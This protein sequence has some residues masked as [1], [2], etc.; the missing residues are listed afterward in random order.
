MDSIVD[1]T[2]FNLFK[3]LSGVDNSSNTICIDS[4]ILDKL[5]ALL[6]KDE[7]IIKFI[8]HGG[9][10]NKNLLQLT[11]D[12][13]KTLNIKPFREMGIYD[14]IEKKWTNFI[15]DNLYTKDSDDIINIFI[16][17]D[18]ETNEEVIKYTETGE[19]FYSLKNETFIK[20]SKEVNNINNSNNNNN[21]N[22][23]K[24]DNNIGNTNNKFFK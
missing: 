9:K 17:Q 16:N 13:K 4:F 8:F 1:E 15:I 5:I 18:I 12:F 22:N 3:E 14:F 2:V 10:A 23:S 20:D 19:I 6:I 7:K 21:N 11:L 24:I